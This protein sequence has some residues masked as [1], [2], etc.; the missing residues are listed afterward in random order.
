M[1]SPRRHELDPENPMKNLRKLCTIGQGAFGVCS[2]YHKP[3]DEYGPPKKYIVKRVII[4]TELNT[5]RRVVDE[6]KFLQTLNH[7]N[8]VE[9]YGSK[10][11]KSEL[12][13]VMHYAEGGTLDR[14]IHD[15]QG[16]YLPEKTIMYYF[17]QVARA[18]RYIHSRK[19]VHRD[20]KTQN[21]LLNRRRSRVMLADFG[22][23]RELN[24]SLAHSFV[25]T[26]GYV[27]P[28]LCNG[29]PYDCKS[30]MWALGCILYEMVELTSPFSGDIPIIYK[31]IANDPFRPYK[32]GNSTEQMKDLIER[33]L[34]KNPHERPSAERV[35]TFPWVL[36]HCVLESTELCRAVT[37]TALDIK[38][39]DMTPTPIVKD[40]FQSLQTIQMTEKGPSFYLNKSS[41][42][43]NTSN[44]LKISQHH[45]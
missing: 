14:L 13:I 5:T 31:R 27:S 4:P 39:C 11:D 18:I 12:Y 34:N 32:N 38:P 28:E 42:G 10:I 21:I 19:I 43:H 23:S 37:T 17:A 9:C 22:I 30:D 7:P 36:E 1:T 40:G 25:G 2:I 24:A 33:L 26:P 20:L 15:Q 8:I 35:I 3:R 44:T 6:A 16:V 29:M 41:S 45:Y